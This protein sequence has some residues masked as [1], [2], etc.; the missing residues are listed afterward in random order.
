M[1]NFWKWLLGIFLG[2]LVAVPVLFVFGRF[3]MF[4]SMR[5]VGHDVYTRRFEMMR[6]DYYHMVPFGG[7]A[8]PL[9]FLVPLAFLILL[10]V[11]IYFLVKAFQRQPAA[12]A[13]AAPVAPIAVEAAA[14]ARSCAHCGHAAQAE[15]KVCPYCAEP[16]A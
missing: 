6:P 15:W 12:P 11:G 16:L 14:P 7:W 9:M 2:L 3:F 10:G 8:G 1:K 13:A 5:W 4:R